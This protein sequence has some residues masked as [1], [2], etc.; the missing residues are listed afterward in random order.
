[1]ASAWPKNQDGQYLDQLAAKTHVAAYGTP[2]TPQ[3]PLSL[4]G[5]SGSRKVLATWEAPENPQGIVGWKVYR[6]SEGSLLATIND[7]NVRQYEVPASS[8][9][10][11][12]TTNIFVSSFTQAGV[13][14][15]A[16]QVQGTALAESGAPPDPSPPAGSPSSGDT[17]TSSDSGGT[18]FR[19]IGNHGFP[20]G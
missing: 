6:D 4:Q 3:P 5:Q 19:T 13:E 7:P 14:S 8:G 17:G 20:Q 2:G 12:P 15:Q 9:S 18:G 1:M 11:P 16:V 10:T